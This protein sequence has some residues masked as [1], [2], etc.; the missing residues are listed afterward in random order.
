MQD[1]RSGNL[2]LC[3]LMRS[4]H[5]PVVYHPMG[6]HSTF[7]AC[8]HFPHLAAFSEMPTLSP[9]RQVVHRAARAL[10]AAP[11]SS[12]PSTVSTAEP[13]N[14]TTDAAWPGGRS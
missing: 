5:I 3:L 2:G 4:Q 8:V 10:F 9:D 13:T 12:V 7:R 11:C 14:V 1:L 6:R